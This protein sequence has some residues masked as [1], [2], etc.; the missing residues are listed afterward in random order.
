MAGGTTYD[1]E[2]RQITEFDP[3][4]VMGGG[5]SGGG[6]ALASGFR[7]SGGNRTE[8][9]ARMQRAQDLGF[10]TSQSFVSLD[11]FFV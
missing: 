4:L 8:Q 1:P 10:D 9:S 3:A 6:S 2:T 7:R 11:Q 5:S